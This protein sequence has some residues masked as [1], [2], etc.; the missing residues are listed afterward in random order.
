MYERFYGLQERAF[1]LTPNP[2][3]LLLT[4]VQHE[5]LSN[6][7]YGIAARRGITLLI[8]EA[9]TGKTTLLR[10]ALGPR[11][12][13]GGKRPTAIYLNNPTLTRSEFL[14]FLGT[15][16]GFG[17]EIWESKVRLLAAIERS[18]IERRAQGETVVLAIDEAQSLPHELLEEVRLLANIESD[19]EKLLPLLL[20]G[21]PELGERL[22]EPGLRQLKQRVALRCALAPLTLRETAAY[23]AGRVRFAGGD[24]AQIFSREAIITIDQYARGIPRTICVICDNALVSG[25]AS[26]QRPIG[27]RLVEGVCRDFDLLATRTSPPPRSSSEP[28]ASSNV[29]S[30]VPSPASSSGRGGGWRRA[31]AQPL[32]NSLREIV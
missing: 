19:T 22:N 3:F 11:N 1:E 21:Q 10:R 16:F 24:P 18:L 25:L 6:L 27:A 26:G 32:A 20:V 15:S 17:P 14:E 7:E 23:I 31:A 2:R 9:G 29:R 4:P 8:G 28:S 12:K 30:F 13:E 5:A